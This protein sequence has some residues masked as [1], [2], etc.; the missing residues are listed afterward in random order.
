M[1]NRSY[2]YLLLATLLSSFTAFTQQSVDTSKHGLKDTVV[3]K[4]IV[5]KATRRLYSE[6]QLDKT[7]IHVNALPSN[8]GLHAADILNNTP[9][10]MVEDD[11]NISIHGKDQAV[12]FIDDKP[13]HLTGKELLSYLQSMP[14]GMLD[15]IEIIPNPPARYAAAGTGGI[16]IIRTKKANNNGFN[17]N[18]T[19]NYGQGIYPKSNN[20]FICNYR[21]GN[22]N[23]Y[24]MAFYNLHRSYYNA[25]RSR[26]Y[27]F[28]GNINDYSIYQDITEINLRNTYSYKL[29][30]DIDLDKRTNLDFSMKSYISPYREKGH[31]SNSFYTSQPDSIVYSNSS[32]HTHTTHHFF[33]LGIV[34]RFNKPVKELFM[35]VDYLMMNDL[36]NQVLNSNTLI[37]GGTW[38]NNN[39]LVSSSPFSV[40]IFSITADF[41]TPVAKSLSWES[42]LQSAF[43]SRENKSNYVVQDINGLHSDNSLNNTFHFNENINAAYSSLK[44]QYKYLTWQVGLRME[45]TQVTASFLNIHYT[46]IFPTLY[47]QYQLDSATQQA[48]RFSLGKRITR[49]DYQSYNPSIFFFNRYTYS[50]GNSMLQ[51]QYT[52]SA[53][54]SYSYT[55]LITV[56]LQYSQSRNCLMMAFKQL[57]NAFINTTANIDHESS[58][59]INITNSLPLTKW[60]L[61]NLYQELTHV[62]YNGHLFSKNDLLDNT[63]NSY[64][65]MANQQFTLGKG[66][67]A[68][69]ATIYRSN[70]LYGQAITKTVWQMHAGIQ[71]QYNKYGSFNLS[72]RDIFHSWIIKKY[73]QIPYVAVD[74]S[75]ENDSHFIG[76]TWN[77][78]FGNNI[79]HRE[80]KSSI[81]TEASRAGINGGN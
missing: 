40:R 41:K 24:G 23:L 78:H 69:I 37:S 32:F 45:N 3:L 1:N 74:V 8:A 72:V 21:K 33:S 73:I 52:Y 4:E 30:L 9:G 64:R 11:G 49:P 44:G 59:G 60:W 71:K 5:V 58:V 2:C 70:I 22:M 80:R 29:G 20:S 54:L 26:V 46:D 36:G 18:L 48:L 12:I 56:G 43:S 39:T 38:Q 10:I 28:P 76:F 17:G 19:L 51:P 53:D 55:R 65:M 47:L 62:A 75:N 50:T 67:S 14:S 63:L 68:D 66:W 27:H 16:I 79:M 6:Q 13:V 42:G 34:H 7:V 15:K 77:Y 31:Y 61:F 81:Q 35:N 57:N 25:Q